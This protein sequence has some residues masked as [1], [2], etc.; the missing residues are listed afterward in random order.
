MAKR[1]LL[2]G[3]SKHIGFHVLEE[4]AP[5]PEKYQLFVIARTPAA[6]IAEF[7]GKT[8]VTFVQGDAK[9]ETTVSNVI[10]DTMQGRV[11]YVVVTVGI[12]PPKSFQRDSHKGGTIV[13]NKYFMPR[14]SDLTLWYF[15]PLPLPFFLLLERHANCL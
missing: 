9:D 12:L 14:F 5:Q 6:R 10:Y 7:P 11:D 8:N 4:L 2:L 13:F 15:L 1:I 3:A